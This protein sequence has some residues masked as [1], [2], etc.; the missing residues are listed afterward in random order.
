[1]DVFPPIRKDVSAE[2][3]PTQYNFAPSS[4]AFLRAPRGL[5]VALPSA[6]AFEITGYS[7]R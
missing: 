4:F 3:D 7:A 6:V 1:V 2:V 5:A